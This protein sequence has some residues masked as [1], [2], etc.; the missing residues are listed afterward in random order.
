MDEKGK[1]TIK[2]GQ[3]LLVVVVRAGLWQRKR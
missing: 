2:I 3:A 1:A